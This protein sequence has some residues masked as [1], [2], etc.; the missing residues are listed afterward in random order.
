MNMKRK[1]FLKLLASGIGGAILTACGSGSGG[2]G[3]GSGS[4][5]SIPVPNGYKLFPLLSTGD[6]LPS[7]KTASDLTPILMINDNNEILVHCKDSDKA[8][9]IYEYTLDYRDNQPIVVQTR[10]IL[11]EGDSLPNGVIADHF[12][13][14]CTNSAGNFAIAVT[15]KK[16]G[17][18]NIYLERDKGGLVS[19]VNPHDNLPGGAGTFA[20]IFGDLDLDDTN[21]IILASHFLPEGE[22]APKQG[23]FYLANGAVTSK[24]SL[25]LSS[26]ELVPGA[27]TSVNRIG[28]IDLSNGGGDYVAQIS[29]GTPQGITRTKGTSGQSEQTG[30][31]YGS[32]HQSGKRG[33]RSISRSINL[34]R[35]TGLAAVRGDVLH[36]P[37]IG[38][39]RNIGH[40]VQTSDTNMVMYLDDLRVLGTGDRTPKENTVTSFSGPIIGSNGLLHFC[41][42]TN[43]GT[44][45]CLFDK[46][47]VHSVITVGETIAASGERIIA[48][49]F[50]SVRNMV[51]TEGRLVFL[52]T[53]E[54]GKKTVVLGIPI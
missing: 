8:H 20:S 40:I 27:G 45:I 18:K 17:I 12:H 7:G 35:A 44:E 19:I 49:D 22:N 34:S 29:C 42:M 47:S 51:D 13:V 37:R 23:L 33:L 39:D 9:G 6:K 46:V 21:S 53:L 3:V 52:A 30:V 41:T 25:L 24:G 43:R 16:N 1:E 50:G 38:G 31:I 54:S 26:G 36:G 14:G 15:D 11:R 10:K 5:G 48:L 2:A 4:N 32:I 28:L